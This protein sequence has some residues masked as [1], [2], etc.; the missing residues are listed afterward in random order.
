LAL[1]V[2]QALSFYLN[3]RDMAYNQIV[4]NT[5][6][7]TLFL[8]DAV[9]RQFRAW[10]NLAEDTAV[11]ITPLISGD[12]I[13]AAAVKK[14]L[15]AMAEGKD[16]VVALCVGSTVPRNAPGGYII[17]NSF[18]PEDLPDDPILDHTTWDYFIGAMKNPGTP[19]YY[20]PYF[21]LL[22]GELM[23][24]LGYAVYDKDIKNGEILGGVMIDIFLE[25]LMDIINRDT[26]IAY[27]DSFLITR[28]GEFVNDRD[29]VLLQPEVDAATVVMRDFFAV[30]NLEAYRDA[31]LESET[32]SHLG[33][34]VFI[35]SAYIPAVDWILV[36]TIPAGN[37]Y[38]DAN[39]RILRNSIACAA[40]ILVNTGLGLIML[41][42]I[43]RERA[44]LVK[45]KDAAEAASRSKSDFLARMSHELRTPL[46]AVIGMSELAAQDP[47]GPSLTEYL[48]NINQA[49]ANLLSII[50]DVLDLSKIESGDIQ[51]VSVSYRLS[52]LINNV[53]SV[54]RVRFQEKP[55]LFIVNTDAGLPDALVGD[56][57]R[58]RQILFNILSN[59]VKYTEKGF[60]RL[61]V[62]GTA[63]ADN[64]I[65]MKFEIADSG[66]GIKKENID[67]LFG[68]FV[69]VDLEHNQ[70]IEGT[71]LG[72]AISKR[73]CNE[74]GGDITVSSVYGEGS[75][76]TAVIPQKYTVNTPM[77][78]VDNPEEKAV[79]LYDERPIY[80][81]SVHAT[82]ENLG[83][84]VTRAYEAEDFLTALST[85]RF[86][87]T[88]MSPDV[89]ERSAA[90][91]EYK[92]IQTEPVI[93]AALDEMSS[94]RGLPVILMPAYAVPVA[95]TLNGVKTLHS[96]KKATV[97]FTAPRARVLIVDDVMTNLKV[98]QG[99]LSG[100]R[101]Q[102]DIC[103]SGESSIAMVVA[104]SY[105]IIFMDHM[106]PGMDGIE[107]TAAIRAMDGEYFK[108]VP[109][110]AL[111]ANALSGMQEMFLSKGFD[112]YLAKPIEINKL[113]AII[114]KWT[115]A[116]KREKAETVSKEAGSATDG[117]NPEIE[118]LLQLKA[119]LKSR[120]R[121]DE[122]DADENG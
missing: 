46:N 30:K 70:G 16:D 100:Y 94:F 77:A 22:T 63:A 64:L 90:L 96:D 109:I 106:M 105:D 8:T 95:N 92:R 29:V 104:N 28:N 4:S 75:V 108:R 69:R 31:V 20:G 67:K 60:I 82:L 62:T 58:V 112:D 34:D 25:E 21:D 12:E 113:G 17:A 81:D 53:V 48:D 56:E 50:N 121:R 98:A 38:T 118:R 14:Y 18:E 117:G 83:V 107:T 71:G 115:P 87:Y 19:S 68:D 32:F 39:A 73:L 80:G 36:S 55:I 35:Y 91:A 76:F 33:E 78:A 102:V 93:L 49:G 7:N 47:S 27:R 54:M 122:Q 13:D 44:K 110:I 3:A 89:M 84:P 26:T 66:I 59:A 43:N 65:T 23:F 24:S 116:E 99:L 61:T 97:R 74:M 40:I 15:I 119:V 5:T 41:R 101:M 57:V 85:G 37:I 114:E 111:T 45:M 10:N 72:L 42:I 79:L 51:L 120:R 103:D 86:P 88:F 11:G 6:E 2:L 9:S 1:N 52:S